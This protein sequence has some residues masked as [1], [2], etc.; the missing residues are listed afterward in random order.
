MNQTVAGED[1]TGQP[2]AQAAVAGALAWA[3][4]GLRAAFLRPVRIGAARVRPH[5]LLLL[6]AFALAVEIVLG[7]LEVDG[8]ADFNLRAW[9]APWWSVGAVLALLWTLLGSEARQGEGARAGA[10]SWLA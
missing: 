2:A 1:V 5:E 7:R 6:A 9:L 3:R 10:V 4:E 8:P